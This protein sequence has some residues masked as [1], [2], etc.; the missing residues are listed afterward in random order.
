MT[1]GAPPTI[2]CPYDILRR[3]PSRAEP[4]AS[5]A[6]LLGLHCSPQGHSEW[7]CVPFAQYTCSNRYDGGIW[8]KKNVCVIL[9]TL[10][11]AAEHLPVLK[12]HLFHGVTVV[13]NFQL[14]VRLC[15][16][17][18]NCCKCAMW[19]FVTLVTNGQIAPL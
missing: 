18:I 5:V 9:A 15:T 4:S 1:G 8:L 17:V 13:T 12:A 3:T 10:V 14:L 11:T 19:Q 16:L 2:V 6:H 7:V